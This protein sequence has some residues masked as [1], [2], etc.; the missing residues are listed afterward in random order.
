M[1]DI[2]HRKARNSDSEAIQNILIPIFREY[3]IRLPDNYSLADIDS[4]EEEYLDRSGEFIVFKREQAIIGF[5][6]LLPS[7]KNQV[8]L[9]RLYLTASER[10]QGLGKFMLK[11]ALRIARKSGYAK[12]HLETVSYFVEAISLYRK[13]GFKKNTCTTLAQGHDIAMIMDL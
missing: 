10:G 8:E 5:F 6:A 11:E 13:F 1:H 9:K 3:N 12:I 4:L 7:V 2:T